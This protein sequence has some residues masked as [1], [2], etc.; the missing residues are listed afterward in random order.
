[1]AIEIEHSCSPQNQFTH[2]AKKHFKNASESWPVSL[3]IAK[4]V[5]DVLSGINGNYF[6]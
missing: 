1:M 2:G 3:A 4:E 6:N 5:Q